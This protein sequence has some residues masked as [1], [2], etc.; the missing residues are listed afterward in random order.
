V[1]LDGVVRDRDRLEAYLNL[2]TSPAGISG[3][4][5]RGAHSDVHSNPV[6][7]KAEYAGVT[8]LAV[9]TPPNL[10]ALPAIIAEYEAS[11]AS[12]LFVAPR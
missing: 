12:S 11:L 1:A 2:I 10:A 9:D 4:M 8:T 6:L 3:V 5:T 7:E